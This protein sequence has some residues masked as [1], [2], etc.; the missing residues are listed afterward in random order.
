LAEL[1]PSTRSSA[2]VMLA[3][4]E[5]QCIPPILMSTWSETIPKPASS[6]AR[7]RSP[8]E[9]LEWVT[10]A[11]S[12]ARLTSADFTPSTFSNAFARLEEQEAQ[13]MPD[14]RSS[15]LSVPSLS[16]IDT[17]YVRAPL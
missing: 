4:H 3:T 15:V 7:S 2:F 5:A 1:I 10:V 14:M 9:M 6:T 16:S 17:Y 11:I 13:C 8:A 12:V